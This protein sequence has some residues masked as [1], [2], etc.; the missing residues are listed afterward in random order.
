MI[1]SIFLAAMVPLS[2]AAQTAGSGSGIDAGAVLAALTRPD[3]DG[4]SFLEQF[5]PFSDGVEVQ[6]WQDAT[7][8]PEG[9]TDPTFWSVSADL[10]RGGRPVMMMTCGRYGH[11]VD[12][13][14]Q[15]GT[16]GFGVT[17]PP[18]VPTEPIPAE[19]L[20][21]LVCVVDFTPFVPDAL[22]DKAAMV[23]AIQSRMPEA[24]DI[25]PTTASAGWVGTDQPYVPVPGEV[26]W[27]GMVPGR[28]DV[29][30]PWTVIYRADVAQNIVIMTDL[31]PLSN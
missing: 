28:V 20:A 8:L 22:P 9:I 6:A 14:I 17:L 7:G 23:A 5:R 29:G 25:T 4:Q 27:G 3:L 30:A 13:L 24:A 15:S 2:A 12:A 16:L 19:A 31:P 10:T 18:V 21:R 11:P 1:R 26:H